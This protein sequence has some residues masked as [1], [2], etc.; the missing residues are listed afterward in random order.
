MRANACRALRHFPDVVTARVLADCLADKEFSVRFQAHRSLVAIT[1]MDLGYE[2]RDWQKV[3]MGRTL[4]PRPVSAA[5]ERPWWDWFG[6][7][8]TS[9]D[10]APPAAEQ[11]PAPEPAPEPASEKP[12]RPWWDWFGVTKADEPATQPAGASSQTPGKTG[13]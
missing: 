12:A 7:T 3:T 6:T 1:G 13:N 2:P 11:K 9:G 4:P 10:E 8:R 5:P